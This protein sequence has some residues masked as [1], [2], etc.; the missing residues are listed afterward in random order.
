[1]AV[2]LRSS[3]GV[4]VDQ[5]QRCAYDGNMPIAPDTAHPCPSLVGLS[6]EFPALRM[7]VLFGSAAKGRATKTSDLDLGILLDGAFDTDALFLALAPRLHTDRVDLIDLRRASPLLA[8]EIARTGRLLFEREPGTFRS[9]Q[10]LACRRYYDT[11][12]LRRGTKERI[13]RF[14]KREGL[15]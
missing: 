10:S 14:L 11:E 8:F 7:L 13:H 3:R 6:H 2:A 1:M 4:R 5:A 9:F 12:R 15:R